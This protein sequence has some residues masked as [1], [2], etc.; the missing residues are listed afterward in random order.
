MIGTGPME[1][2]AQQ[3]RSLV[4]AM[5]ERIAARMAPAG[6]A[7]AP[8]RGSVAAAIEH[9]LLDPAATEAEVERWCREAVEHAF[10]AV[11]VNPAWVAA[12]AA[13]LRGTPVAVVA[14][15]GFPLGAGLSSVL[16]CEAAECLK[17]GADELD[18]VIN[19][20]ALKSGRDAQVEGEIRGVTALA[21]GAGGRVKVILE[22]GRLNA[23]EKVHACRLALA[24]GADF[25][26]T[27]TGF[28]A[29]GATVEDVALLR[30]TV[31]DRAGVKAAGGIRTWAE[32]AALLQAGAS[33]LGTSAGVAIVAEAGR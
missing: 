33:R 2:E 21:H 7:A 1:L 26:K 9:T 24:A 18:M 13:R 3:Y 28:G 29:S 17:L 6:A 4:D 12:A 31:G 11:C 8:A 19:L 25:V 10:A 5:V 15:I 22:C 27:S 32:A 14:A 16:R 23:G 20:G 30:A